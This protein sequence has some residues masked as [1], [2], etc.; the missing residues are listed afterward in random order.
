MIPVHHGNGGMLTPP[1]GMCAVC[2]QALSIHADRFTFTFETV[3]NGRARAWTPVH[4]CSR[5]HAIE[6]MRR[7]VIMLEQ[8]DARPGAGQ[9]REFAAAHGIAL[10]V[11]ED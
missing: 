8:R 6:A 5:A 2:H 3:A 7:F 9:E 11:I 1:V 10:R 4:A